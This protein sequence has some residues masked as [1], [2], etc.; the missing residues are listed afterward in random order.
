M[1]LVKWIV[2]ELVVCM[3]V[4]SVSWLGVLLGGCF[5]FCG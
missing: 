1:C 3:V 2:S 5:D 4:L